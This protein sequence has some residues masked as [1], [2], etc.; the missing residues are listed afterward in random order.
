MFEH[1]P[2]LSQSGARIRPR[3]HRIDRERLIERLVWER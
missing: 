1:A 2:Y 3:L